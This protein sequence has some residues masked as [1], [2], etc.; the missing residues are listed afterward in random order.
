MKM[1]FLRRSLLSTML[2][3][4]FAPK[5][6]AGTGDIAIGAKGGTLG[7][8][9]EVTVGIIPGV[10]FRTGYNAF[11][12]DGNTTKSDI[13]YDYKLKLGTLPVLVDWHPLPLSGFRLTTGLVINNN[14]IDA[15]ARPRGNYFIGDQSY[16]ATE[17]GTL[18][19]KI[20]FNKVAPYAG[21]GWGNAVGK[22][23]PIT[24]TCDVG[25]LFQGTPKVSLAANGT[26][27]SLPAFQTELAK[28]VNTIKNSTDSIKYYPVISLGL[29][30]K[31]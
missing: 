2:L 3:I 22:H 16:S 7:I 31:F 21:I 28:E 25:V 6:F 1:M 4:G 26:S 14:K 15:T 11:N 19:G 20:E 12:Y 5:V 18:T 30:Y 8:G 9:G 27:A 13:G 24:L 29:A 10:N 17:I 23:L